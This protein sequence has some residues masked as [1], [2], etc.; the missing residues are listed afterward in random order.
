MIYQYRNIR[1][2][3]VITVPCPVNG[4]WEPVAE[5]DEAP[6]KDAR[7]APRKPRKTVKK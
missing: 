5:K 1:T 2:G 6:K 7:P 4:E 3:A